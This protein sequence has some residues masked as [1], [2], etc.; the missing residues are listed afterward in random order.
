MLFLSICYRL[1]P[2]LCIAKM[3]ETMNYINK[4]LIHS[5][6]KRQFQLK[7]SIQNYKHNLF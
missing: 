5:S 1:I 3:H 2:I 4:I 6:Q 7:N